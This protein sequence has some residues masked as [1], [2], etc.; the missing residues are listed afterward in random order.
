MIDRME[1]INDA[2]VL[3][4]A[5]NLKKIEQVEQ[6]RFWPPLKK[7]TVATHGESSIC[8]TCMV[9]SNDYNDEN[10]LHVGFW[11]VI[12]KQQYCDEIL[13]KAIIEEF[14]L[15]ID[16]YRKT[17]ELNGIKTTHKYSPNLSAE[18]V[19]IENLIVEDASVANVTIANTFTENANTESI[20]TPTTE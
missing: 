10:N 14:V 12:T 19:P 2:D 6:V 20:V 9:K 7:K 15:E 8:F 13:C 3:K 17:G 4:L 18:N 16:V 5:S 11:K 1:L